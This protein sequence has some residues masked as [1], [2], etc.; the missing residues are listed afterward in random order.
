MLAYDENGREMCV[1][2]L[3]ENGWRA[4]CVGVS[5]PGTKAVLVRGRRLVGTK[6]RGN[7]EGGRRQ[8]D[9]LQNIQKEALGGLRWFD[10]VRCDFDHRNNRQAGVG[11]VRR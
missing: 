9:T 1:A 7:R 8:A 4:C 2:C 6:E 3:L 10:A 5:A 11:A